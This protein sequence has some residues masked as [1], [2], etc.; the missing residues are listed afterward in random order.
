MGLLVE[1][2]PGR[3]G[4]FGQPLVGHKG[5]TR[6]GAPPKVVAG[7]GIVPHRPAGEVGCSLAP[8]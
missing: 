3:G 5:P 4:W 2:R 6:A 7:V 8:I 1:R